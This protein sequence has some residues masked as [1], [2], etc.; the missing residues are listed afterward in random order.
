ARPRLPPGLRLGRPGRSAR[1]SDSASVRADEVGGVPPRGV[2]LRAA[3]ERACSGCSGTAPACVAWLALPRGTPSEAAW[4]PPLFYRFAPP[5]AV[6]SSRRRTIPSATTRRH[7]TSSVAIRR[8]DVS[9]T[10]DAV[11]P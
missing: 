4:S 9:R 2:D 10:G 6:V 1:G 3:P 8:P 5:E 11:R 7:V